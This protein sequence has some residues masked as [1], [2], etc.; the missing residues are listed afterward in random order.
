MSLFVIEVARDVF[1]AWPSLRPIPFGCCCR[2][3]VGKDDDGGSSNH[4][5]GLL[6]SKKTDVCEINHRLRRR[7]WASIGPW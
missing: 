4:S 6:P 2:R 7:G 5:R 1:L 3:F